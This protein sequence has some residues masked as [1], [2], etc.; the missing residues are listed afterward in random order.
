MTEE[1]S[2]EVRAAAQ[3][4]A[5]RDA[6]RLINFGDILYQLGTLLYRKSLRYTALTA[7]IAFLGYFSSFAG[8]PGFSVK[9]ALV[10]PLIVGGVTLLSGVLLRVIP[11]VIASR[12]MMV[13]QANDMNL[14]EDYRKGEVEAHL[15]DLWDRVY[16]YEYR[17]AEQVAGREPDWRAGEEAFFELA[18]RALKSHL[19]QPREYFELGIDLHHYEDWR[20]GA[21][22]DP[23]DIKLLEQYEGDSGITAVKRWSGLGMFDALRQMPIR[24]VQRA[25]LSLITRAVAIHVA[26]AVDSL[27]RTHRTD[28]FNAQ[29][30]IWPGEENARWFDRFEG[31]KEEVLVRRKKLML[32]VF[33]VD[34]ATARN[35]L[36]RM[37]APNFELATELRTRFDPEYCVGGLRYDVSADLDNA[38]FLQDRRLKRRTKRI[39]TR[40]RG[41]METFN[42]HLAEAHPSLLESQRTEELRAVRIAF[43]TDRKGLKRRF[44]AG[45]PQSK[46]QN[47][48]TN[49]TAEAL[50]VI[51][52]ELV[53]LAT[54][55]TECY[56]RRLLS[57]RQHHELTR[58]ERLGYYRLVDALWPDESP[59]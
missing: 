17:L 47:A 21:Y 3:H 27:N 2:Q 48:T 55:D 40:A 57:L 42:D 1:I 34:R 43:L 53:D 49:A 41:E 19:S 50:V 46:S 28:V 36:D 52:T 25:W 31:A 38:E 51:S 33:G 23:S 15:Q 56:S 5:V 6:S 30:L 26:E 37:F 44:L 8:L 45:Q 4:G 7:G 58:L 10:L 24:F 54:K 11:A 9:Q 35:M 59:S 32:R 22:F 16:R 18:N 39:V 13:A 14:M 12:Q 29:V 20:D